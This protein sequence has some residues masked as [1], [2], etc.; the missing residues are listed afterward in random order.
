[1]LDLL[2]EIQHTVDEPP[3]AATPERLAQLSRRLRQTEDDAPEDVQPSLARVDGRLD[4]Y[5]SSWGSAPRS[6]SL[7]IQE[8]TPPLRAAVDLQK[9]ISMARDAIRLYR[10]RR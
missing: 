10:R 1:M 4:S 2:N 9:A 6:R 5:R 3:T 8:G 7:A